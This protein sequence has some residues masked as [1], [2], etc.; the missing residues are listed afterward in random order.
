[1]FASSCFKCDDI[2]VTLGTGAFLDVN[3][4]SDVHNSVTGIYPLVAWEI[5]GEVVKLGEVAC[6]DCGSLIQ[7]VLNMGLLKNAAESFDV[8]KNVEDNDGVYFVPAFSGLGVR[9][10]RSNSKILKVC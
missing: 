5:G 3:T 1:M 6:N 8:V 7:W 10:L 9:I 4:G 2:K